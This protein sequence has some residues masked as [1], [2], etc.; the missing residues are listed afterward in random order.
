MIEACGCDAPVRS[1]LPSEVVIIVVGAAV[2]GCAGCE[3]PAALVMTLTKGALPPEV[4]YCRVPRSPVVDVSMCGGFELEAVFNVKFFTAPV[5][6]KVAGSD[7]ES[8][9][10]FFFF[11]FFFSAFGG[12][13]TV[14]RVTSLGS[15]LPVLT[16]EG[17]VAFGEV[18]LFPAR[19]IPVAFGG[20]DL[21]STDLIAGTAATGL[22]TAT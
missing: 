7:G 6:A 13:G 16:T 5:F 1:N 20:L 14:T 21:N 2:V 9:V 3:P 19:M 15:P 22:E 17:C 4:I 12:E 11:S 10:S 8:F 18:V